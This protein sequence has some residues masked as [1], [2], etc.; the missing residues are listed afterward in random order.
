MS[1]SELQT[2]PTAAAATPTLEHSLAGTLHVQSALAP[3]VRAETLESSRGGTPHRPPLAHADS[4]TIDASSS[5]PSFS[6]LTFTS[7]CLPERTPFSQMLLCFM[8]K[9]RDKH[10]K[11]QTEKAKI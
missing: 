5:S 4:L 1:S 10:M 8:N 7:Y 9:I 11:R 3:G 2:A 6:F